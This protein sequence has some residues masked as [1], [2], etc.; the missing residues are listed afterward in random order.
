MRPNPL[1]YKGS[2]RMAW[3]QSRT[4]SSCKPRRANAAAR[5][6]KNPVTPLH[7]AMASEYLLVIRCARVLIR[8]CA[9]VSER[10]VAW[11]TARV[12]EGQL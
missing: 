3:L 9:C 1:E 2:M 11:R 8:V 10:G 5:L 6:P 12:A 7:N 4:A